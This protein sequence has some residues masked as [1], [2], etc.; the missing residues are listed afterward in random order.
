MTILSFTN[1]HDNYGNECYLARELTSSSSSR[2]FFNSFNPEEISV[3]V[4]SLSKLNAL[5]CKK[6][7]RIDKIFS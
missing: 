6:M 5:S 4:T 2:P 7:T 1:D 3:H